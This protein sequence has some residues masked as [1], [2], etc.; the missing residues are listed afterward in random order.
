MNK[1]DLGY[2]KKWFADYAAAFYTDDHDYNFAISVKERHTLRV[3]EN[4]VMIGTD[5]GM[6]GHDLVIAETTALF[7]DIGRFKQYKKYGTFNDMNSENHARL[8]LREMATHKILSKC[9]KFEKKLIAKTV[10]YHNALKLPAD[11]D[12]RTLHFIRLIRDADKIDIWKF[13]LELFPE[14]NNRLNNA[15]VLELPDTP[16][17]S[18]KFIEALCSQTI[19]PMKYMKTLNDFKLLQIGWVYDLNFIPSLQVVQRHNIIGR[20]E[21]L[22]PRSTEIASAVGLAKDYVKRR[23]EKS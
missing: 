2:L 4:I 22:L 10:N 3:C 13:F 11:Q 19:A 14:K 1:N 7:H 12:E 17:Y 15:L 5:L 8:G 9:L 20:F 18:K 23:L 16:E 21:A 6:S